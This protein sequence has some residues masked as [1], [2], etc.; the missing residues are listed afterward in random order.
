MQISDRTMFRIALM[1]TM[2]GIVGMAAF[3]GEISPRELKIN[4]IEPGM[5]DQEV[6]IKGFVEKVDKSSTSNTYFL[7]INDGTGKIT[8]IL[9][10]STVQE[11]ENNGLNIFQMDNSKIKITGKVSEYKGAMELIL[12]DPASL[13]LN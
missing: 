13:K 4:Q 9:F 10:E 3:S 12:D 5:M 8:V 6:T 7:Q 11:I 1:V 2:V